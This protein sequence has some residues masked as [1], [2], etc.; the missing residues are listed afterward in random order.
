ML[1]ISHLDINCFMCIPRWIYGPCELTHC[2]AF[3]SKYRCLP[4][5]TK[6]VS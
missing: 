3:A 5:G 1:P 6:S 2:L 4:G